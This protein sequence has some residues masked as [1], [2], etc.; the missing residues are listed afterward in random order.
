M[1]QAQVIAHVSSL[2]GTAYARDAEGNMRVLKLGDAIREGESVVTTDGSQVMLQLADGRQMAVVP[3]DVVRID[4]E[5]AADFKPDATDSA[6]ANDPKVFSGLTGALARGE[7]IDQ[8]LEDPAAGNTGP[9][10]EGHSFVE[11]ARIVEAV[12]PLSYQYGT[13]RGQELY[14][15]DGSAIGVARAAE[16]TG[17]ATGQDATDVTRITLS[18]ETHVIEGGRITVT[19]TVDKPVTDTDLVITLNDGS[20]ITIPVGGTT[21]SVDVGTRDDDPYKQ[22]DET[23]E[24]KIDSTTGGNYENLNTDSTTSTVVQDDADTTTITLKSDDSVTEG[25]KITVT[26]TVDHAPETDL[27]I[28]LNDGSQITIKA[29]ETEGSVEVDA[30]GDDPYKQ[31]DVPVE[32][33]I[34]S[35]TG[36]NYENLD[37]SSTTSTV[38][39]D[40]TDTT[41]ITLKSDD[42]VTEGGKITVTATV[43]N[44]PETDLVI[45]LNDGSEITIKAGETTGSVEVDTRGD[46]PY[47]QGDEIVE[48]KIDSTTGGNYENLDTSSTTSTVVQDN[49]DATRITLTSDPNVTEGDK[50][51]VTATV[52]NAPQDSD[53]VITLNDGSTITIKVGDTTGSVQV[54]TR[55]D[56][57]YIQGDEKLDFSI[58]SATGGNYEAL[59]T[60]STASTV[61]QDDADTSAIKL[62][63]DASVVD[64]GK[65]TVTASVDNAPQDTDLVIDLGNGHIITIAVGAKTGSIEVTAPQGETSVDFSIKDATGGNYEHLDTSS[66]TSTNIRDVDISTITLSSEPSVTEG[67]KITVTATVDNAPQG[68]DLVITLNDGSQITIK[69]GEFTGSVQVDT[70]PDD[71]YIQGDEKVDFSIASTTG[72]NYEALD[73]SSTASTTVVD[74]ADLTTITLTSD[75]SVTEGGKI[76]VTAT[77]DHAPESDLVI[78]LNDGSE[79]TILAN[80][81]T[82]SVDVTAPQGEGVVDFSIASTSGGNYEALDTSSTTSTAVVEQPTTSEANPDTI[83]TPEDV[84]VSG[85]VL[86]NDTNP[87]DVVNFK[88]DGVTYNAGDTA[89][90]TGKGELTI[91]SN[92]DYTF[93]PH[94]DY[95]GPVPQITY[96]TESGASSTLDITVTPVADTPIVTVT[97]GQ[98]EAAE[99]GMITIDHTNAGA[100]NLGFSVTAF[101]NLRLDLANS[102]FANGVYVF[103]RSGLSP[104]RVATYSEGTVTG[105]GSGGGYDNGTG[106]GEAEVSQSGSATPVEDWRSEMTVV[107]FDAPVAS[108]TVQFIWLAIAE[109]AQYVAYDENHN[110]VTQGVVNG[111][112]NVN[113]A[114]R[115]ITIAGDSTI[116][117]IEFF[118]PGP[119]AGGANTDDFLIHSVQFVAADAEPS[120]LPLSIYATPADIDGSESITQITVAV[121]GGTL[122]AGTDNGDGTWTFM[123]NDPN[124]HDYQWLVDD[125]T[126]AVTIKDLDGN[127][128]NISVAADHVG[129]V[130][131]DV[132]ATVVDSAMIGGHLVTDT[133]DGSASAML[134]VGSSGED[135]LVGGDGNDI[136]VGGAGNDTLTGGLGSDVFVWNLADKGTHAGLNSNGEVHT[137][138][139][140]T[141]VQPANPA[142]DTVTDFNVS[143]RIVDSYGS[144]SGGDALDLR[145]LLQGEN[146][147]NLTK[148]L[149]FQSDGQGGT[150]IHV[151]SGGGFANGVYNANFEDQTIVLQNVDLTSSY[152]GDQQQIIN[153]LLQNGN[154]LVD[155]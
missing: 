149:N 132:T 103:D 14:T 81:T 154:L 42:N 54:D 119:Y 18:S 80:H 43:D 36:G 136:L 38:V 114:I 123:A 45:K 115:E 25:G 93:T 52:N 2:N 142:L 143:A 125:A 31:G 58:A 91:N 117:Y 87:G 111:E 86:G 134:L 34:D 141:P 122:S 102:D 35:T 50:I 64:G 110:V 101:N 7:N 138:D 150:I 97:L 108:A 71:L 44:P 33:K 88:V 109:H 129:G 40:D 92:G 10:K 57:L 37:T 153:H 79:I 135:T 28:T 8:L 148:Y 70:R 144:A 98:M 65:I 126:G 72:G 99:N 113:D 48:F 90:I 131:V 27:V 104:T 20:I 19:A 133:T 62:T 39:K 29:G 73:T 9:G 127:N 146:A 107:T 130:T 59:D 1:A 85:N 151:S 106:P 5:V 21:G 23:V 3:G 75:P 74:D 76:T 78:K 22:G 77:V 120:T 41:T 105:F 46:D 16:D 145:D 128:L 24:F 100:D 147:G 112:S 96:N 61:V 82:G 12:T 140:V 67:D 13:E 66:T 32:F 69:E 139:G 68:G 152:G 118:A 124:H 47:K 155:K 6:V 116:K 49:A 63:S 55:P 56:D 17:N 30:R 95:S 4:A 53:L 11:L 26:A 83:V 84:P 137:Q 51:T 94:Q 60:S 121:S 89:T 15:Y